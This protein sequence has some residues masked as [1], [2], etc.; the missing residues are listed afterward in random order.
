ML[1]ATKIPTLTRN[2]RYKKWDFYVVYS[3]EIV[4]SICIADLGVV[5]T[6]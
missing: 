2:T 6:R 5:I 1:N 3:E 4:I